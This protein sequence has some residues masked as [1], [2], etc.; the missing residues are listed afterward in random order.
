MRIHPGGV[1]RGDAS[2]LRRH[3]VLHVEEDDAL[4]D[5]APLPDGRHLVA[6]AAVYQQNPAGA[7]ISG[8][9]AP[10][11]AVLGVDGG[12]VQR[13]ALPAAP[14]QNPVRSLQARENGHWLVAGMRGGPGTHTTDTA[15]LL[16]AA[17]ILVDVFI[18][19]YIEYMKPD[20]R[21][22]CPGPRRRP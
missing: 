6:G 20:R 2:R 1:G 7:S 18:F 5:I 10:L 16:R 3:A 12:I 11:L 22:P 21:A 14:G 13:L 4:L 9:G 17:V 15:P 8:D 19:E